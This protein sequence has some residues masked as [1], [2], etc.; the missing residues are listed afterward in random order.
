M[1]SE[2]LSGIKTAFFSGGGSS[3]GGS[4]GGSSAAQAQCSQLLG[5]EGYNDCVTAIQGGMDII[6]FR[7]NYMVSLIDRDLVSQNQLLGAKQATLIVLNQ[8]IDIL[9]KLS[10]CE[11]K[12]SADLAPVQTAAST[13]IGQIAQIQ[14]DIIALQIKR[15][16][17]K[18]ITELKQ[19]TSFWTQI[20]NMVKPSLTGS[21]ALSAQQETNQKQQDMNLYQQRLDLCLQLIIG[22]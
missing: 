3:G 12:I 1:F 5:T 14:S 21:L 20:S 22:I 8:S 13:T 15:Q 11:L 7:K 10:D 17:I 6:E 19:I 18:A 4:G 9:N 16:E 2:G